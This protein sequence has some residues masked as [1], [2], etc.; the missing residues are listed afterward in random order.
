MGIVFL[1]PK[2][3]SVIQSALIRVISFCS[4]IGR[5]LS[6]MARHPRRVHRSEGMTSEWRWRIVEAMLLEFCRFGFFFGVRL[7]SMVGPP[8]SETHFSNCY[9]PSSIGLKGWWNQEVGSSSSARFMQK[10]LEILLAPI[11]SLKIGNL[12]LA[13][14]WETQGLVI[15]PTPHPFRECDGC[16]N[17]RFPSLSS[18]P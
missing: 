17:R 7:F 14:G 6:L 15:C 8:I 16:C 4:K 3:L 1:Y 9:T 5:T 13:I 11:R 10:A 18:L 12:P 2:A